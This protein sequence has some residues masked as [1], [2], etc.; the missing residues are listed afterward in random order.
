MIREKPRKKEGR[1]EKKGQSHSQRE[2]F[3]PTR[4]PK[5]NF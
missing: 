1:K 4:K 5:G 3:L 2:Q